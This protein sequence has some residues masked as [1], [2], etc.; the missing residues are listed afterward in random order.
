M[1]VNSVS[2]ALA[3]KLRWD[4]HLHRRWQ[5]T[6]EIAALGDHAGEEGPDALSE[7]VLADYRTIDC[8]GMQLKGIHS[9][10]ILGEH[11]TRLGAK[12]LSRT[13]LQRGPDSNIYMRM[14][15]AGALAFMPDAADELGVYA[16]AKAVTD[17][18]DLAVRR[19][20]ARSLGTLACASAGGEEGRTLGACALA[21]ALKEDPD[22][23]V[24]MYAVAALEN[25]GEH[26]T[27]AGAVALV[28]A[29][30][31]DKSTEIR[32]RAARAL[33]AM[34]YMVTPP[35]AA[36][37]VKAA[38]DTV[39]LVREH[40]TT[41]V[42]RV[43]A[44]ALTAL[45]SASRDAFHRGQAAWILGELGTSAE[46]AGVKGLVDSV[47]ADGDRHVRRRA[48]EALG[49]LG[50]FAGELGSAALLYAALHDDDIYVQ[51]KAEELTGLVDE[52]TKARLL[53]LLG[54]LNLNVERPGAAENLREKAEKAEK[55]AQEKAA[56][57]AAAEAAANAEAVRKEEEERQRKLAEEAAAE[58]ERETIRLL[59]EAEAK[60]K[61][62]AEAAIV[63]STLALKTAEQ[64]TVEETFGDGGSDYEWDGFGDAL[65]GDDAG[66]PAGDPSLVLTSFKKYAVDGDLNKSQICDALK[67]L[68]YRTP[69]EKWINEIIEQHLQGREVL[70]CED[71]KTLIAMYSKSQGG[72]LLELF[73]EADADSSGLVDHDELAALLDSLG[74]TPATGVV[75]ALLKEVTGS[76]KGQVTL[77]HFRK[78]DTIIRARQGFTRAECKRLRTTYTRFSEGA[79]AIVSNKVKACLNW[80]GF[81][82][83]D[84]V[85]AELM[86]SDTLEGTEATFPE[87]LSIIRKYR[88]DEAER[89]LAAVEGQ[90]EDG[91]RLISHRE[92][93]AVLLQVGYVVSSKAVV[94]EAAEFYGLKDKAEL[95]FEDLCAVLERVRVGEGFSGSE[96]K[97]VKDSFRKYCHGSDEIIGSDL[98]NALL[99]MG[100]PVTFQDV[101]EILDDYDVDDSGLLNEMEFLKVVAHYRTND[102]TRV[103][104]AVGDG[105]VDQLLA[106]MEEDLERRGALDEKVSC[107]ARVH[108]TRHLSDY[109]LVAL[110]TKLDYWQ[111]AEIVSS[112]RSSVR[113][114]LRRHSGFTPDEVIDLRKA[115]KEHDP[116]ETGKI[117]SK[118]LRVLL[119][120]LMPNGESSY[121]SHERTRNML[122]EADPTGTGLFDEV[123]FLRL[124]RAASN[125]RS[126]ENLEKERKALKATGFS[127]FERREFRKV[128]N[129]YDKDGSGEI[130][131]TELREIVSAVFP[132]ANGRQAEKKVNEYLRQYDEDGGARFDFPEFLKMMRGMVEDQREHDEAEVEKARAVEAAR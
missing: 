87:F 5:A 21:R 61:A 12:S 35:G 124:M 33:G 13:L 28:L 89:I 79:T 66:D 53:E 7:L 69:N 37:L 3:A 30:E 58:A 39:I 71:Y 103:R 50:D 98:E 95:S 83:E 17:D 6:G 101:Q 122:E 41:S 24:R 80:L 104:K 57:E 51:V 85:L 82:A 94:E 31:A 19:N 25:L 52:S 102:F 67:Q 112:Y 32:W 11:A 100:Y 92:L 119:N 86:E 45:S 44:E 76:S 22:L 123:G 46:A 88:E 43:R 34:G 115:F 27:G 23:E 74:I 63:A 42:G 106:E 60:L 20:A 113:A 72:R 78:I 77:E 65:V 116:E 48:V 10:G 14:G 110:G 54:P 127:S 18:C 9:L 91:D 36:A 62:D 109:G 105:T 70:D 97:D 55:E 121:E 81:A 68:G 59:A 64:A 1:S 120:T 117:V 118:M 99:W 111:L 128:Y 90:D 96:L 16:L 132:G 2:A 126:R 84:D 15:A 108:F 56:A 47:R 131:A 49:K 130:D 75:P 29:L 8:V 93:P 73:E 38:Q 26:A 4:P 40:A 125:E 114:D 107:P 129:K